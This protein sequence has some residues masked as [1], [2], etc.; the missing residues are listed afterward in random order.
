MRKLDMIM[1]SYIIILYT[2][3]QLS[4]QNS[5]HG[6]KRINFRPEYKLRNKKQFSTISSTNIIEYFISLRY[7][8]MLNLGNTNNKSFKMCF[9]THTFRIIS[10]WIFIFC[11]CFEY[12]LN[13]EP[14]FKHI[15]MYY[16]QFIV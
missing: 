13:Q 2:I 1:L 4:T 3:D 10:I 7:V 6:E 9:L 11:S 15:M 14:V 8:A 5:T 16:S 12:T